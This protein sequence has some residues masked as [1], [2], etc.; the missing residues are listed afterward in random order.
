M[1]YKRRVSAGGTPVRTKG[2]GARLCGKMPLFVDEYMIDRNGS[3]AAIRAG[4]KSNNISGVAAKLLTHPLIIEEI[5]KRD[6]QN[7][8][9]NE[10]S[11]EYV[12]QKLIKIV[13]ATETSSPT[14]ALRGLELLGK[15]LALF[16]ERQELSGPDGAAIEYEQKVKENVADF[17]SRIAGLAERS[18]ESEVTQFPEPGRDRRA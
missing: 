13:E 15:T 7:R 18:R 16:K 17:T 1:S 14:N 12:I 5:T 9:K 8:E 4:Y 11:A 10:L 2:K 6:Q 3:Q